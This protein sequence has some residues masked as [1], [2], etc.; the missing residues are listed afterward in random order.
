MATTN[1]AVSIPDTPA[2]VRRKR[3]WNPLRL[4]DKPFFE[5]KNRAFWILQSVG[6]AGYFFLRT[7]SNIANE[8]IASYVIHNALLTAAGYS[9]TLLMA[10]AYRRLIKM[11]PLY[12][13]VGTILI[14]A[15]AAAIFSAIETWSI[16][17]FVDPRV[18][19]EGL[20][21]FGAILFTL[22]LLIAW[23]ALYYSINFFIMLEEQSDRLLR[24]ES[25]ASNAQLAMLR[26]QLNPHFLFNTLNSISTLVLL[27]QT[28]R[29]NAMLSRLSSFL[30]YTL[31]NESTGTVTLAQEVETLKLYLEIEKMRFEERL[32]PHFHIDRKVSEAQLPSLLLQPLIENAIKY[33]V[34]PQE[35]GADISVEARLQTDRVI[36]TVSDTGPGADALYNVRAA[37]STGVGLANIRDRLAQAYGDNHRFETQSDITGGFRVFIDIPYQIETEDPK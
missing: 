2:P 7:L 15:V 3:G 13:W 11:R 19:P 12:T 33:A 8:K 20:R 29:A 5:D 28:D 36:I 9:I 16:A 1:N 35:Q 37:Q 31:V 34:T 10:S 27:K 25:Q 14:V 22:S 32:R 6:W 26:Y 30:R 17:T 18:R 23:S 24:L 4:S 21:F